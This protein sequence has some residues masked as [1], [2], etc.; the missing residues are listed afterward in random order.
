MT[1]ALTLEQ[2]SV[3][4]LC[5]VS[6]DVE[7]RRKDQDLEQHLE[8]RSKTK[9]RY[10]IYSSYLKHHWLLTCSMWESSKTCQ[11]CDRQQQMCKEEVVGLF[12]V[13]GKQQCKLT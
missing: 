13:Y 1:T 4:A 8:K 11:E 2:A 9:N 6:T 10:S 7:T 12:C 5:S 3:L